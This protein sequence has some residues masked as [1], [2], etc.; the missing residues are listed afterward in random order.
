MMTT[1]NFDFSSNLDRLCILQDLRLV[2][3][4][5][6]AIS[7]IDESPSSNLNIQD[8]SVVEDDL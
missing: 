8:V 2:K 7:N 5:D 4:R 3:E 1:D 6:G